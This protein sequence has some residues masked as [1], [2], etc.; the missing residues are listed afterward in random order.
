MRG[1]DQGAV[2]DTSVFRSL[3]WFSGLAV[4]GR[5]TALLLLPVYL[6][7]LTPE[8]LGT[9]LLLNVAAALLAVFANLQIHTAMRTFYYDFDNDQRAEEEYLGKLF[10]TSL[11]LILVF[12]AFMLATGPWIYGHVFQHDDL[13]F[14]PL[15]LLALIA[16]CANVALSPLLIFMR[17]RH[18]LKEYA[19]YQLFLIFGTLV[20]QSVLII[21]FDLGVAGALWGNLLPPVLLCG[22]AALTRPGLLRLGFDPRDLK[23][24]L[25]FSLPLIGF[26]FLYLLEARLDRFFIER[27]FDMSVVGVYGLLAAI[28]GLATTV[29]NVL[30]MGL[31]PSLYT[32]LR[33]RQYPMVAVCQSFYIAAGLLALSALVLLGSSIELVTSALQFL[34]VRQ[35]ITLGV[36]A[37]VPLVFT[38]YWAL[39]YVYAKQSA[40]LTGWTFFRTGMMAVL[41]AVLVPRYE[42]AGALTAILI[43]QLVNAIIFRAELGRVI[44]I[45]TPVGNSVLQSV[46]VVGIIWVSRSFVPEGS[47]LLFGMLQFSLV[48]VAL[49]LLNRGTISSMRA[50][51]VLPSDPAG[52]EQVRE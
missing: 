34:E 38:R 19:A 35:W 5:S 3:A 44:D 30:D 42:I 24:S 20:G 18:A 13:G 7:Y 29:M 51:R 1:S 48:T 2:P 33:S 49:L 47:F 9:L 22:Y 28:L 31:R 52:N 12:F 41:L 4:I 45:I 39:L 16:V 43:S 17:N 50:A 37:L 25:T 15:G 46:I 27:F 23:S 8:M 40:R 14:F 10:T 32:A 6:N 21:A 26:S 36:S 11:G